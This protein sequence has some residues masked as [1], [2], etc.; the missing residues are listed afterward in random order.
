[1]N[2]QTP[3]IT[4]AFGVGQKS[5]FAS[6]AGGNTAGGLSR[7]AGIDAGKGG[8]AQQLTSQMMTKQGVT[9]AQDIHAKAQD[10]AAGLVSNALILPIL[11]QVRRDSEETK[12]VFGG[13]NGEKAFGPQF[14]MQIADRIARSPNL[15][16]KNALADRLEKH[17]GSSKT[18]NTR[19][20]E[21]LNV[22]G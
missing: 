2:S 22:H 14:D 9:G 20:A 17:Y 5:P 18:T 3:D 12:S 4:G 21:T 11:K 8:F 10:A 15:G 16:I 1:M 13:G 6:I 7:A 19:K